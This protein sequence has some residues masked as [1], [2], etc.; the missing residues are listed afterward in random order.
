MPGLPAAGGIRASLRD[1][2][3]YLEAQLHPERTSIRGALEKTQ[4]LLAD[5]TELHNANICGEGEEP[6]VHLCNPYPKPI[7]YGWDAVSPDT[8]FF[9][10]GA[11]GASQS[12]MMF[13]TDRS[14]GV[15]VL[16]NSKVGKGEQTLYHYPNDLALCVFQLLGK[17]VAPVDFCQRL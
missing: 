8:V 5:A 9:H 2:K 14:L 4:S 10:G 12:M 6:Y 13:S 1:M 11:T 15:V 16:S 17:P 3:K 7:Y